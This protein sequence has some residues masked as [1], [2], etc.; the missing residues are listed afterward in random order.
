MN[1]PN[2]ITLTRICMIPLFVIFFYLDV[3]SGRPYEI[4]I[5]A[6][7]FIVAASTDFLDGYIARSRGLVTNMGKFLDP[8]ADKVLNST[9]FIVL[10]TRPAVFEVE[11]FGS[12]GLIVAGVCVAIILA[13]ELIV[14]GFRMIAA[15]K[16]VVLAA[17]MIGKAK[18]VAQDV[19]IA[20]LLI[21]SPFLDLAAG[22]VCAYV[23][24]AFL[25]LCSVLTVISGVNYIV[26]NRQVLEDD[27]Q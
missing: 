23:G 2:K 3:F 25:L 26:K 6:I 9:A 12:Y 18:T 4:L 11:P 19:A 17:D 10:L 1:L 14:S 7:I 20:L 15:G 24:I 13:R 16:K 5:A 22:R 8:I 27:A 21:C